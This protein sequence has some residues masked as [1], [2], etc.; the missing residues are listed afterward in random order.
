MPVSYWVDSAPG[1]TF[2]AASGDVDADGAVLGAG[3]VGLTA[4]TLL[5][6]AGRTVVLVE[7][8]RILRGATGYT[9]A[10]LTSGHGLVYDTLVRRFGLELARLYAEANQAA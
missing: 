4:A 9:T 10:K 5:K 6:R 1:P 2:P 7:A 8:R 3:I